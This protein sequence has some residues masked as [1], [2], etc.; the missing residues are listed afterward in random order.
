MPNINLESWREDFRT[1][2]PNHGPECKCLLC[3]W[4]PYMETFIQSLLSAAESKGYQSGAKAVISEIEKWHIKKGG[5]TEIA[6]QLT[7]KYLKETKV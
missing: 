6:H 7:E 3:E 4:R 2:L 5:Y 1:L